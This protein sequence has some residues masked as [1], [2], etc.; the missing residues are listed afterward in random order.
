MGLF[1]LTNIK[2]NENSPFDELSRDNYGDL[3]ITEDSQY[4]LNSFRFP[5]DVGASDKGH[6]MVIHINKQIK[7]QYQTNNDASDPLSDVERRGNSIREELGIST[8]SIPSAFGSAGAIAQQLFG[9]QTGS[10]RIE[11]TTFSD[12]VPPIHQSSYTSKYSQVTKQLQKN[13]F[14]RTIK[15]TTDS[16]ALY[17]PDTLQFSYNQNYSDLQINQGLFPVIA[18][19]GDSIQQSLR[20]NQ[21]LGSMTVDSLKNLA[22]FAI[23]RLVEGTFGDAGLA[24]GAAFFGT[25]NN[26]QL[27]LLYTSPEFRTFRFE[28]LLYPRSEKEAQQVQQIIN[29]LRFHQAPEILGQGNI[30]GVGALYLVPPSEFDI[31]FY[32]NGYENPNIP[33]LTTCVLQG[34]DTDYAPNGQFS[35]YETETTNG[36]PTL[37][38]TGMPVGIRLSL[39]FKE[40][41]ILTKFDYSKLPGNKGNTL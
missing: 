10:G 8:S 7:T 36:K 37:G 2:I 16:I 31:K 15:R 18:A 25:V 14:L 33:K 20:Q 34:I 3:N 9:Q 21:S 27:E 39:T 30:G 23:R 24:A 26:P 32:Y 35:A 5:I 4:N 6:Y 17:M 29:R 28:F 13:S 22:P 38:G 40:T 1:N 41:A 19:A 11:G 12:P